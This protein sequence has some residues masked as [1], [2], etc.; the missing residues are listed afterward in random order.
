MPNRLVLYVLSIKRTSWWDC[1]CWI[2]SGQAIK[3]PSSLEA[4]ESSIKRKNI[5]FGIA[6]RRYRRWR[7]LTHTY[8]LSVTTIG[9]MTNLEQHTGTMFMSRLFP[10]LILFCCKNDRWKEVSRSPRASGSALCGLFKMAAQ[11]IRQKGSYN[12]IGFCPQKKFHDNLIFDRKTR[13]HSS[14]KRTTQG[15]KN[16]RP[17]I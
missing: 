12:R 2:D 17:E 7:C 6:M 4:P 5:S 1:R 9:A 15:D 11:N 3:R 14:S 10:C 16:R 13:P 8:L